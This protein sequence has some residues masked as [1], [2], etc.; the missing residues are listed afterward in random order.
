MPY[1]TTPELQ[2]LMAYGTTAIAR[3]MPT[4]P[5]A[6]LANFLGELKRDGLPSA[7]GTQVMQK[8]DR[9]RNTGSEY[10]NIEFA[11]R[12]MINDLKS[13][14]TAVKTHDKVL[15]QYLRDSGK[16]IKRG[17]RFPTER[18]VIRENEVVSSNYRPAVLPSKYSASGG[19]L[20]RT[21]VK[22]VDR[23]FTGEFCYYLNFGDSIYGKLQQHYQEANKLFGVKLTPELVWNLA[24]WSWA[25]DWFSNAGDVFHNV[26]AFLA[27]GLVMRRAYVMEHT[28]I[29][30]RY[31]LSAFPCYNGQVIGPLDQ[32]FTQERKVRVRASPFGFGKLVTDLSPRQL[33]IIAALGISQSPGR[34]K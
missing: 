22:T 1:L 29:T 30:D 14:G 27:D 18:T 3:C 19:V 20:T 16:N 34:A 5:V 23:W 13:F 28:T 11:W 25:V 4:N 26:S 7:P 9:L 21:T 31:D 33:A 17:Y 15:K 12:P 6:G 2:T 8:V 10:L 32:T 24:P